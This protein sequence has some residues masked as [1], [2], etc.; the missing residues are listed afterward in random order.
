MD[1]FNTLMQSNS[2]VFGAIILIGL[3]AYLGTNVVD[4][5]HA[6]LRRMVGYLSGTSLV[7]IGV[8]ALYFGGS[9]ELLLYGAHVYTLD[10]L[11]VEWVALGA[12][13]L[14]VGAGIVGYSFRRA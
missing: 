5:S 1:V 11:G 2:T 10:T 3:L 8:L 14:I 9:R 13:A 4:P 7:L 6:A 12:V